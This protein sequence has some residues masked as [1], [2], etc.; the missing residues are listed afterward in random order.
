[1]RPAMALAVLIIAVVMSACDR[2]V[3]PIAPTISELRSP[4]IPELI[5]PAEGAILDNGC[6]DQSD[7]I[8]WE[9]DWSDVEHATAYHLFVKGQNA[10]Y[11][12]IDRA[13]GESRFRHESI[14]YIIARHQVGWRWRVRARIGEDW[15]DWTEERTFDVE[16]L[17]SDCL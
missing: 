1:M 13:V 9:F 2:T 16:P 14:G 8:I 3:D 11:P 5:A 12:V 4:T 6:L 17:N 10:I 15:M 7:A